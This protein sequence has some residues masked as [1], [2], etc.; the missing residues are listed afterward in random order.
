MPGL[1]RGGLDGAPRR[2][3]LGA[4]LG[5]GPSAADGSGVASVSLFAAAGADLDPDGALS[6]GYVGIPTYRRHFVRIILS[7][8]TRSP[9]HLLNTFD[10]T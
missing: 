1:V 10:P 2:S 6:P 3:R 5:V 9:Y 4:D 8:L 7:H